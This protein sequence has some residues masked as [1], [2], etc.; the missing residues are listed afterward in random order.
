MEQDAQPKWEGKVSAELRKATVDQIWL[1]LKD[2][3]NIHKWFP[4]L[5]TCYGVHGSNGELG[6]IRYGAGFAI[7]SDSTGNWAKERLI[8]IDHVDRSLTYE[9]VDC[10]IGFESYKATMKVV[11]GVGV[12]DQGGCTI[13]WFFTVDPVEGWTLDDMVNQ[14]QVS[15][16][17]MANNMEDEIANSVDPGS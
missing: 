13:H 6:C 2:F 8:A 15:L 7:P 5:S 3:F 1:L 16:Q 11:P 14:Y 9:M 12:N 17:I 4:N 10:N